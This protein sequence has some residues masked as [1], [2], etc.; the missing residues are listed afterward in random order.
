M[1]M[2]RKGTGDVYCKKMDELMAREDQFTEEWL[3]DFVETCNDFFPIPTKI[4]RESGRPRTEE[5]LEKEVER[6][7][8]LTE[9]DIWEPK[10]TDSDYEGTAPS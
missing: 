2:V 8:K 4:L 10:Y 5:E 9:Q 7:R 6:R 3:V 1:K